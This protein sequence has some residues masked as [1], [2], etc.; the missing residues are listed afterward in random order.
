VA[1]G[2]KRS[3][4]AFLKLTVLLGTVIGMSVAATIALMVGPAYA[5]GC[6]S[7]QVV[8]NNADSGS[9]SLRQAVIDA[10]PGSTISFAVGLA[11]PI[12][13]TSGAILINE[14]LTIVGPG[15]SVL[16]VS[17]GGNDRVFQIGSGFAS[18]VVVGISGLTITDGSAYDSAGGNGI[19]NLGTLNLANSVVS[20]N[21][22][23]YAVNGGAIANGC[24]GCVS[25]TLNLTNSTISNN[26]GIDGGAIYNSLSSA[27]NTVNVVSSTISGNTANFGGAVSNYGSLT[28]TSSTISGNSGT[29]F[30]GGLYNYSGG[31]MTVTQS[32]IAAN[33]T[34]YGGGGI[35]NASSINASSLTITNSTIEG[36]SAPFGSGG[37]VF[38]TGT[39][40]VT[41][42]TVTGN[43]ASACGGGIGN[44]G[45]CAGYANAN[46]TLSTTIAAG[47]SAGSSGPDLAGG[48]F[49]TAGYNLIGNGDGSTGITNGVNHDQ[50]GTT[51]SP[52]N[53]DLSA[54]ANNGGPT[55]TQLP[56]STS[57]VVNA[58]PKGTN[59]CGTAIRTDQRGVLR[60]QG[61]GCDIGAYEIGDVA[62]QNLKA[63]PKAVKSG[64]DVSFTATALNAGPFD[65]TGV[66]VID[67]L[68]TG[69]TYVSSQA[70]QGSCSF[71]APTVTCTLGL[72]SAAATATVKIVGTVTAAASTTVT[73]TATV[74]ATTGDT[75]HANDKK[76]AKITV[77]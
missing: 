42:S 50:V 63:K 46:A 72:L 17:G 58:I 29:Y 66:T 57:P 69:L 9:G 30:G 20:G 16:S 67:T 52:I 27:L 31:T 60:P 37:G 53:P 49:A 14:N 59:G 35:I 38:N 44:G 39:M 25:A 77:K 21:V 26:G 4:R 8:T 6:V 51:A 70:S 13:L 7:G 41:A 65:A 19:Y 1:F 43:S 34:G 73:N 23:K 74:S 75:N 48:P 47:N 18:T 40:T 5:S 71:V 33:K 56:A 2:S 10:C 28:V 36:N 3:L 76:T 32:T 15:A 64:K 54:L 45:A 68:P 61:P 22:E 11:S 12:S 24:N 55:Q 62:M